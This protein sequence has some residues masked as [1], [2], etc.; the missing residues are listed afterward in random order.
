M[1]NIARGWLIH[2]LTGSAFMVTTV[3]AMGMIPVLGFSIFGGV[4]ADRMDRRLVII[5]SDAFNLLVLLFLTILIITDIVQVWHVFALSLFHGVG[6]S[7]GMPARTA[8]V[9]N[10]LDQDDAAS[11]VA[12]FSTIFSAGQLVGPALA[13]YLINV[14]GMGA[15]FI[16]AC[17]TIAPALILLSI[18]RV[19]VPESNL[20]ATPQVSALRSVGQGLS[21]VRG[22]SVLVGL[23]LMGLA[24]TVFAMPYQAILPVFAGDVL[25]VG[26]S[27]LGWLG[28][29]GG[30]GAIAGSITVASFSAPRQM[31]AL[32]IA[33]GLGLGVFIALFALSTA[34]LL[35]LAFVLVAG[36][37]FQIFITGNYTLIQIIPPD[38]IRGRVLSLRMVV[39][40]MGPVGMALL[41]AGAEELGPAAATAAMGM[42]SLALLLVIVW[43][44]PSIRR[45]EMEVE[46]GM[47]ERPEKS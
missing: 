41:G 3:N 33:S 38:Y 12:L 24:I 31:K 42:T 7:L 46:E 18:L 23:M 13:G 39:V 21:Y 43:R 2:D 15:A 6:F 34:Y 30:A 29:M 26:P 4:I 14:Y 8:T 36:Y 47:V 11:G 27:G 17:S 5:A 10:L 16:T 44:I 22:R 45:V 25:D 1:T 9:S 37:L 35:S 32:M 28:A 20:G 40:G 19:S